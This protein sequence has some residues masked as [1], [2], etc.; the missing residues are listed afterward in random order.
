VA[1]PLKRAAGGERSRSSGHPAADDLRHRGQDQAGDWQ[2]TLEHAG[3]DL[4]VELGRRGVRAQSS[5]E[6]LKDLAGE[7]RKR[8]AELTA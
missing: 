4:R 8:Q 6:A 7:I 3:E 5:P 1:V 2:Q